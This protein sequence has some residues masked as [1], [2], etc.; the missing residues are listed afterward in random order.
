MRQR[1]PFLF[2]KFDRSTRDIPPHYLTECGNSAMLCWRVFMYED[3]VG[4]ELCGCTVVEI[5]PSEGHGAMA[6]VDTHCPK[7][8]IHKVRL[9]KLPTKLSSMA[10]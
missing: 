8:G 9:R 6:L 1:C 3:L 2:L 4:K 7:C 10:V 5:L